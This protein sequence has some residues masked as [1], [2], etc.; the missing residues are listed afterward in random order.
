MLYVVACCCEIGSSGISS[1]IS[2]FTY[3][4]VVMVVRVTEKIHTGTHI[5]HAT[6]RYDPIIS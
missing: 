2:S 4:F 6:I 1:S 5:R 3:V